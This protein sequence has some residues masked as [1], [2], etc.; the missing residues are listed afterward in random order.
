MGQ[1]EKWLL[2]H[3]ADG[4][5]PSFS[6]VYDGKQSSDFLKDWQF[7]HESKQL[8]GMKTEHIFTYTDPA[9]NCRVPLIVIQNNC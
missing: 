5:I 3:F 1:T 8:D 6:F 2:D 9:I 7:H 4:V